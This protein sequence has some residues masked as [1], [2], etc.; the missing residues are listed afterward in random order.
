MLFEED[1]K[2]RKKR[3][4]EGERKREISCTYV[5]TDGWDLSKRDGQSEGRYCY[6]PECLFLIF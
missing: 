4:E 1:K 3:K 5:S 2:I 6:A